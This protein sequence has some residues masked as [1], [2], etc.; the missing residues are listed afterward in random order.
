MV[1]IWQNSYGQ[2]EFIK[3]FGLWVEAKKKLNIFACIWNWNN[4]ACIWNIFV[5][6]WNIFAC[7][8][9]VNVTQIDAKITSKSR[10]T[11][12]LIKV[13]LF[14]VLLPWNW[15]LSNYVCLIC[16]AIT[17]FLSSFFCLITQPKKI[18]NYFTITIPSISI[19]R[20]VVSLLILTNMETC[21]AYR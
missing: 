20:H 1:I 4:F 12:K 14:H 9:A 15:K 17:Y 6:V 16:S 5:C 13:S 19:W 18:I 7:V 8:W 3:L 10:R 11:K 21:F 2:R